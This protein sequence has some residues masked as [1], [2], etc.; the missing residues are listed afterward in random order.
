[1]PDMHSTYADLGLE[2]GDV[3]FIHANMLP[4]GLVA[5]ERAQFIEHFLNPLLETVGEEGTIAC[6]AYTFSYGLE[7]EPY[8]HEESPSE[9]GIFTEYVRTMK[10]SLRSFHPLISVAAHG[11]KA[12][13]IT[14]DVSRAAFGQESPFSRLYDLRAKCLYIGMTCGEVCSCLHYVEQL[15][16]VSHC[17]NKAFFH[18][19][20]KGGVLEKGPFLA[21]L[22][23]RKSKP[24]NYSGFETAMKMR[25]HVKETTY[26]GAPLQ[27]IEIEHCVKVGMEMLRKDSCAF[28]QEPFYITE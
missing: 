24:Y 14:Q 18:P 17:Y 7:G 26:R 12:Q 10:G 1:M 8:I 6:L 11:P 3:V 22:R 9:A 21:F 15:Y 2:K 28:L 27:V 25:G 16:G 20:Y 13:H 4:F 5:R 19:A 23:N